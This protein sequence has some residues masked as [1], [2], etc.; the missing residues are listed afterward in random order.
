MLENHRETYAP[1]SNSKARTQ[2]EKKNLDRAL[3][4]PV[5]LIIYE[6]ASDKYNSGFDTLDL[7]T[8]EDRDKSEREKTKGG[9]ESQA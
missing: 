8:E 3:Y 7:D 2:V 6:I 5:V 9:S 1:H 4:K